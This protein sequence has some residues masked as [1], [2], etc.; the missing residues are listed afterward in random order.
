[1]ARL[2]VDKTAELVEAEHVDALLVGGAQLF[3]HRFFRFQT[4]LVGNEHDQPV[5]ALRDLFADLSVYFVRL[6]R[7]AS[8]ENKTQHAITSLFFFIIVV[9][10]G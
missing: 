2:F 7:S 10:M 6:S 5:A 9:W 3:E 1:M 8:S 4:D